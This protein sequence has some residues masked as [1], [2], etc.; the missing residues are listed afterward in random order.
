MISTI[1]SESFF[2]IPAILPIKLFLLLALF[3]LIEWNGRMEQYA[4]A[5]FALSWPK[6]IRWGIYYS[7]VLLIFFFA[8]A[9]Q[10]FIYFQF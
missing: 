2:T 10:Q 3:I 4:I 5:K 1:G 6:P 7:L 8:G 9:E